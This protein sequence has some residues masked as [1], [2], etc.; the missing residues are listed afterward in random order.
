[1]RSPGSERNLKAMPSR[2]SPECEEIAA[3]RHAYIAAAITEIATARAE[4]SGPQVG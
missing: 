3:T 1:M 2:M 4:L